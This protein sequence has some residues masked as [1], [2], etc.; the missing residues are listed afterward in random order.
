MANFALMLTFRTYKQVKE[1]AD[2]KYAIT[3]CTVLGEKISFAR[4]EKRVV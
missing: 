2:A 1:S 3:D 4:I